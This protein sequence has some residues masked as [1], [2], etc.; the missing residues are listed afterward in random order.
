MTVFKIA[1]IAGLF[2]LLPFAADSLKAAD[3]PDLSHTKCSLLHTQG[4]DIVTA[5][6]KRIILKGLALSNNDWGNWVNGVSEKLQAQGMDP[7]VRPEVQDAWVLTDEDFER[8]GKLGLNC[9]RYCFNNQLF[10]AGNPHKD[11]NLE[12]LRRHIE[13]FAAMNIYTVLNCN[14]SPG[15][16]T[17]NEAVEKNKPRAQRLKSV[18]EDDEYFQQWVSMWQTVAAALKN[19]PGL[20]GYEITNEPR[21]PSDKEGGAAKFQ[22]CLEKLCEAIRAMDPDHILFVP[23]NDSR[24]ANPGESYWDDVTKSN[25]VDQGEGG[26]LWDH[27]FHK[28]NLP[29]IVYVFHFY[30]PW[31]F[32]DQGLGTYSLSDLDPPIK[33]RVDWA[34][35]NGPVPLI[36]TEYGITR[37]NSPEKRVAWL[38]AVQGLFNQYGISATCWCYKGQINPY[39]GVDR[40]F[41]PLWGEWTDWASEGALSD[42]SYQFNSWS[43]DPAQKSGFDQVVEKYYL[44]DGKIQPISLLDNEKILECLQD[45]WK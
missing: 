12:K 33:E 28:V 22:A 40:G 32:C 20:A 29:N 26:V 27:A 19:T 14:M 41:Y 30:L 2:F 4:S 16:D 7:L 10:A 1:L 44:K 25:K 17:A 3:S 45:Y 5:D 35:N 37:I 18:F 42:G 43:K 11:E 36:A 21:M 15:L 13:R 31:N 34:A 24:E 9:V 23:E 6:G 38:L 8:I 39:T